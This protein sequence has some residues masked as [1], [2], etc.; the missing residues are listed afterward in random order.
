MKIL[1]MGTPDFAVFSLDALCRAGE[2]IIGVITQPDKPKGRGYTLTPPPVKVYAQER[3]IPVWQPATLRGE[4]F[5]SLL[6]ELS[7][8]LIIVVAYGKILPENVLKF[9][10]YG[11]VNVHGSL[12]PEY[13]G[14]AP[15]Q[16]AIIDGKSTTG[17]TTMYM[18][19]GL[20]TG[21]MILKEEVE[22]GENDNFEDIHDRLGA[23]GA[24]LLIKTV[25]LIKN[26]SAP[27]IPQDHSL[28]TYAAKIEKSDCLINFDCDAKTAHDLIRGLSPIPL[29]FT[30]TPDGKLLKVLESRVAQSDKAYADEDIGKVISLDG[31]A[32]TV[33]CRHGAIKLLRV[34]PEGKGRMSAADFIRGRKIAL[35]DI[36][37]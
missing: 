34:L 9:A 5:A 30:H 15:M 17:I 20:D 36:L 23:C 6:S 12:L 26:G 2:E 24:S 25:E 28:S 32:I 11:C 4:E 7:P 22:I 10:K 14:A 33:A 16:R 18:D 1:F 27:S 37:K 21:N 35:G 3:G 13:R 29:A 19:V 31:D 8:E